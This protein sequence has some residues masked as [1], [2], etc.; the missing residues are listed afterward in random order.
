MSIQMLILPD[1]AIRRAVDGLVEMTGNFG[2]ASFGSDL[3]WNGIL[4]RLFSQPELGDHDDHVQAIL[5]RV[6]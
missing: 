5:L 4:T 1:K 3:I 2:F 6:D